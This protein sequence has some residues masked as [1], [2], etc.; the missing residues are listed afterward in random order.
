MA[1]FKMITPYHNSCARPNGYSPETML[2]GNHVGFLPGAPLVY[3]ARYTKLPHPVTFHCGMSRRLHHVR[4]TKPY[5][6]LAL[7][8]PVRW[9]PRVLD[10]LPLSC[11][12]RAARILVQRR[13][14]KLV[15]QL[16]NRM[17]WHSSRQPAYPTSPSMA[18]GLPYGC[19]ACHSTAR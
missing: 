17:C 12:S 9:H 11:G 13:C 5:R 16:R 7:P 8:G 1:A 10:A 15:V 19:H 14:R 6:H 2:Q 3:C 18:T 4:C